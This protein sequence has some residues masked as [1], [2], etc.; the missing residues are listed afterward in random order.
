MQAYSVMRMPIQFNK[1]QATAFNAARC[2]AFSVAG[3]DLFPY[4]QDNAN[5]CIELFF[6]SGF[7]KTSHCIFGSDSNTLPS[8]I[9]K[10]FCRN[11]SVFCEGRFQCC[12]FFPLKFPWCSSFS[13]EIIS[14]FEGEFLQNNFVSEFSGCK[15]P[16]YFSCDSRATDPALPENLP[17]LR[18]LLLRTDYTP[19]HRWNRFK[20]FWKIFSIMRSWQKRARVRCCEEVQIFR[21][22]QDRSLSNHR[23][24]TT[25]LQP[26]KFRDEIVFVKIQPQK[27]IISVENMNHTGTSMEKTWQHWNLPSKRRNC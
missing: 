20:Q 17:L 8:L 16:L 15:C 25:A 21:E 26:E 10:N 27:E 13:T 6:A 9:P 18:N 22:K 11:S 19:T 24:N 5:N 3:T 12:Q 4:T 23:K 1:I 2:K 7:T 14:P